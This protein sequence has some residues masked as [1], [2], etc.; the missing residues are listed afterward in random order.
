MNR[1]YAL[2]FWSFLPL[3]G[4]ALAQPAIN[5]EAKISPAT[6]VLPL[7][8]LQIEVRQLLREDRHR[9]EA[10]VLGPLRV[11]DARTAQSVQADQHILVLNGRG[12]H[13][14]LRSNTP[15]R[16]MQS[17]VRNGVTL[18]T[19]G[20]VLLEAST[21]FMATPRWDG[22]QRVELEISA[23]QTPAP[24]TT[25][26]VPALGSAVASV[27]VLPLN[28]WLT[29]AQSEQAATNSQSGL[30]GSASETSQTRTDVQVRISL[31]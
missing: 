6:A 13:I 14:A 25:G 12:A 23:Q 28:E 1:A 21:G 3:S 26:G 17:V 8:N 22:S 7:R 15:L 4:V 9:I 16:L 24:R 31:R 19:Q 18:I 2:I 30:G 5:L 10:A 20:T 11:D 27:L 29:V